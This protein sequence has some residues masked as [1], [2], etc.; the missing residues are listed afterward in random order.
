[1]RG[2]EHSWR[3][4]SLPFSF[5]PFRDRDQSPSGTRRPPPSP[6]AFART[7]EADEVMD[8]FARG[9]RVLCPEGKGSGTEFDAADRVLGLY[10]FP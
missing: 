3:R 7:L 10:S 5:F 6:G 1:M 9:V 2:E 8:T 4:E